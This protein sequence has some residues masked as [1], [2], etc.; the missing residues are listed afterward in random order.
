MNKVHDEGRRAPVTGETRI[1]NNK[2]TYEVRFT[3]G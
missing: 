3:C 1:D 2:A